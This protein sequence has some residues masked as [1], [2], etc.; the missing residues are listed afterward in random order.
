VARLRAAARRAAGNACHGW[1]ALASYDVMTPGTGAN[2]RGS[3]RHFDLDGN[4][5]V[6]PSR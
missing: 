4:E 5:R 1:F 6:L 2:H 3:T